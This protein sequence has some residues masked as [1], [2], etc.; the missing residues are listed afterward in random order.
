MPP[1]GYPTNPASSMC[2]RFSHTSVN[3]TRAAIYTMVWTPEGR[4]VISGSGQGEITLWNGVDFK[5]ELLMQGHQHAIN[6]M[7]WSHSFK[8]L[9]SGDKGGHIKYW[10]NHMAMSHTM[11]G[12][13]VPVRDLSFSPTDRK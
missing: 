3:K 4:R 1:A 2:T 12:H 11:Q 10:D 6:C 9:I 8:W 7:Q 5:F 13:T